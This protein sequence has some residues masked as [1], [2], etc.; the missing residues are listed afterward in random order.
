MAYETGTITNTSGSFTLAHQNLLE[1]IKNKVADTA[2]M[3]SGQE[4]TVMRYD[5]STDTHELILKGVGLSGTEEIFVG[6]QAYHDV[7]ADYY[8]LCV[9]TFTGYVASNT[10]DNQPG[11]SGP[12][13]VP[14]HNTS[15]TYWLIANAQ[16]I[17]IAMKV[18]TPV[19]E[20]FYIGK[21]LPYDTPNQY[22]Y[23]VVAMG[24]F[25]GRSAKRFSDTDY[26][27]PY[28]GDVQNSKLRKLDGTWITPSS[29]PWINPN[30]KD[31]LRDT[32]GNY[33]ILPVELCDNSN[34]F[35]YLD[36]IGYV[37]GFNNAVEN[38]VDVNG[39]QYLVVQDVW[40][41]GFS[42]YFAMELN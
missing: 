14:A 5:T 3:G 4:W 23:P 24:M 19:Y 2:F 42:D 33:H 16:R 12:I 40:R 25:N 41:T 7:N 8:N 18:G 15:I 34:I 36:G 11:A 9:Q 29:S 13:G 28:R 21:F 39:K 1:H 37:S 17:A 22:P 35:G 26:F 27:M 30:I 31:A 6:I 20:T 38:I 32:E 10:F